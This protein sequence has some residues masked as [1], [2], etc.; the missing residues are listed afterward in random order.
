MSLV[1]SFF[2]VL[3]VSGGYAGGRLHQWYRTALERDAAW[4]D[5]YDQASGTLFKTATKVLR[6][7]PGENTSDIPLVRK[8]SSD[9]NVTDITEAP[10]AGRHS[11]DLRHEVTRRLA[12]SEPGEQTG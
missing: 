7:K 9:D 10:S 1:Y 2:L 3:A 5:G 4:R 11:F 8:A 6:R 12:V